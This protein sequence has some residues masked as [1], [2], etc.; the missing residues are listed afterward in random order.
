MTNSAVQESLA[1]CRVLVVEDEYF[2]ADDIA[3]AL[4]KL[5]AEVIGPI[6][7]TD[8]ALA[9]LSSDERI[10]AAILDINLRGKEIF[11]VADALIARRI[12]VVFATGYDASSVPP[13]YA[14]I[15]RWEKPFNPDVLAQA[16]P[17]IVRNA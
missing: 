9:L 10:D 12:P 17:G 7:E 11:P 4:E 16:L 5:G 1:R 15:P 8:N 14:A 13:A 2:M 3:K 6:P